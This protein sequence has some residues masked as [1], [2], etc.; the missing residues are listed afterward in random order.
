MKSGFQWQVPP[1]Q[2]FP[3][4]A[5]Q[6]Q[7]QLLNAVKELADLYAPLIENWMKDNA[8]WQDVTGL[9][10]ESLF[11]ETEKLVTSVV[12]TFGHGEAVFYG[13]F[14]E[15]KA[16]GKFAVVNPALDHFVP[17]IRESLRQLV[18]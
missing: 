2:A 10:R 3:A 4:L 17:L 16:Q 11:A 6:Q 12:I 18:S 9:A 15:Y 8:P 5:K 7:R 13:K 1:T 14:L